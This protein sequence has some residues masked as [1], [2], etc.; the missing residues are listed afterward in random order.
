MTRTRR[1]LVCSS[2][3]ALLIV[4]SSSVAPAGAADPASTAAAEAAVAWLK[5]KQQPDGG[6]E[7]TAFAG[8]ETTDA[9][10]AI[11]E[12]AQTGN[13]WNTAEARAA[14]EALKAGGSGPTPLDYLQTLIANASDPAVAA[15]NAVY[16]SRALGIDPTAFGSLNLVDKMGG[17]NG[18]STL[19]FNGLLYLTLAQAILCGTA[20]SAN[21]ATIRNAQQENGGWNF[22]GDATGT[23]IDSDSTAAA[24]E[25]LVASGATFDDSVV[26][27]A[28]AFFADN[29]QPDGAWQ[30]FGEDDPN[31]T[32][33]AVLGITAAGFD[34]TSSCWRDT[35]DPTA[36]GTGYADPVA[37]LRAQQLT[38]GTDVGRIQSPSDSF[39]VNTFATSQSVEGLL[40]SWLPVAR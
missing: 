38:T 37:W 20:P 30:S 27:K 32:A 28:I 19:G 29:Q 16:V 34:V 14:V 7:Q 3:L 40:R 13:T 21:V 31:S 6:F 15:K 9:V 24:V 12:G 11:A 23:D 39:G 22:A 26:R 5:T 33:M 35:V 1:V 36:A 2:A 25:A 18:S 10:V 8:F 17:C 4:L